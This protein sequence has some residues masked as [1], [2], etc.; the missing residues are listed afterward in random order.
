MICQPHTRSFV[1]KCNCAKLTSRG[2][3][4]R[5]RNSRN[6]PIRSGIVKTNLCQQCLFVYSISFQY[7][8]QSLYPDR[9]QYLDFVSLT[10]WPLAHPNASGIKAGERSGDERPRTTLCGQCQSL[11]SWKAEGEYC[12]EFAKVS[13]IGSH[14]LPWAILIRIPCTVSSI[15]QIR[16]VARIHD[17]YWQTVEKTIEEERPRVFSAASFANDQQQQQSANGNNINWLQ[18]VP[19]DQYS[20][21][22][23]EDKYDSQFQGETIQII[24]K[25]QEISRYCIDKWWIKISCIPLFPLFKVI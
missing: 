9:M 7:L 6:Q 19:Y 18:N 3:E 4:K 21:N 24:I 25:F 20:S 5:K 13:L 14:C 8:N 15:C 16:C 11:C 1:T 22:V 23:L 2:R 12:R 10:G 17:L